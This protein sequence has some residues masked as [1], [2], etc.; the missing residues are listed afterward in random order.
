[1]LLYQNLK[2]CNSYT[3]LNNRLKEEVQHER[4]TLKAE[5]GLERDRFLNLAK[6]ESALRVQHDSM[7]VKL[8]KTETELVELRAKVVVNEAAR[9]DMSAELKITQGKIQGQDQKLSE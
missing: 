7:S 1:M 2:T 6:I 5:L 3:M 8:K 9:V 4:A